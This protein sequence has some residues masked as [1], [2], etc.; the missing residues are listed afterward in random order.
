[1]TS[2]V[3]GFKYLRQCNVLLT[4]AF[5]VTWK[6]LFTCF[7]I[8]TF[9]IILIFRILKIFPEVNIIDYCHIKYFIKFIIA[10]HLLVKSKIS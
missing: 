4:Y 1:M 9:I 3:F 10:L 7:K 5:D 2:L 8:D 6:G